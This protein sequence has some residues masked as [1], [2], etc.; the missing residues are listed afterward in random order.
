M[1][2][3]KSRRRLEPCWEF[4]SWNHRHILPVIFF[5][6]YFVRYWPLGMEK[7]KRLYKTKYIIS[8]LIHSVAVCISVSYPRSLFRKGTLYSS[9]KPESERTVDG[10]WELY[11]QNWKRKLEWLLAPFYLFFETYNF[12]MLFPATIPHL[13]ITI[14]MQLNVF[15]CLETGHLRNRKASEHEPKRLDTAWLTSPR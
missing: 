15:S 11:R 6:Y 2:E 4:A 12:W 9:N 10:L 3:F 13:C 5:T 1:V 14:D 8:V 7:Q